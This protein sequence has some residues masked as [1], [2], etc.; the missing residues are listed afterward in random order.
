M[1]LNYKNTSGLFCLAVAL[2][3]KALT[4]YIMLSF[5]NFNIFILN[6]K[7]SLH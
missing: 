5:L 2:L 1:Y 4:A 7:Y 3:I 6:A